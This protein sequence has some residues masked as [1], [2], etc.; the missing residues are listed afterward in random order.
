V[1]EKGF[2]Y[3]LNDGDQV[4]L[5][6]TERLIGTRGGSHRCARLYAAGVDQGSV[7]IKGRPEVRLVSINSLAGGFLRRP[8]PEP[9]A[10]SRAAPRPSVPARSLEPPVANG[11]AS[12]ADDQSVASSDAAV[13]IDFSSK[14]ADSVPKHSGSDG[15][16]EMD[17]ELKKLLGL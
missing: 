17:P 14:A 11:E 1:R 9:E 2:S 12:E 4:P 7:S 5:P 15:D 3:S 10:V 13:S 8:W 6:C 16:L